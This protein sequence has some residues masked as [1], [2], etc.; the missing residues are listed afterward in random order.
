MFYSFSPCPETRP[1]ARARTGMSEVLLFYYSKYIYTSVFTYKYIKTVF[2]VVL[3]FQRLK[4]EINVK[5]IRLNK[6]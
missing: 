6:R 1:I 3:Y 2:N 4:G 5:G